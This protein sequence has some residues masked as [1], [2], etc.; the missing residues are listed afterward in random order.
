MNNNITTSIIIFGASGDLTQRKLIPSF[1]NLF[2]KQRMPKNFNII[3]FGWTPF[4][5]EQ[6]RMHLYEGLKEYSRYEF[7]EDEWASFSSHLH[8]QRGKYTEGPDFEKLSTRLGSLENGNANRL[9]YMA[10][11][12]ASSLTSLPI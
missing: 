4:T 1:F 2:C 9:Y 12:P 7:T 8:Y 11:P 5:D 3:G 10:I 6:F